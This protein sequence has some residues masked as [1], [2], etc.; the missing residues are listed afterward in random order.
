MYLEQYQNPGSYR[1]E[2]VEMSGFMDNMDPGAKKLVL[3]LGAGALLFLLLK[4][5]RR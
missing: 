1:G 4:K 3:F 5:K 2:A